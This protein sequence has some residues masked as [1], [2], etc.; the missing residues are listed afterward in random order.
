MNE[1]SISVVSYHGAKD[2]RLL[3]ESIER[4]AASSLAKCLYIV[5]NANE[6]E[7]FAELIAK[8][9]DVEYVNAGGNVGF[10][11]GHG[12]VLDRLDS[13]F[14]VIINPDVVFTEDSLSKLVEFMQDESIGMAVPKLVGEDGAMLYVYR[15]E[16][17]VFDMFARMF[18]KKLFPKRMR[19]V[20]MR[21]QDYSKPF[22]VPFAQGSFMCIRTD[23]WKKIGGFDPRY[24]MYV[25]DAD[26]C[27]T[28]NSVSK[29]MYAPCTQAVHKWEKG[30]HR[31][32]KLLK[33]HIQSMVKYM[34][35]WGW[36]FF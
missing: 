32:L 9:P 16:L 29:V 35:K 31:N 15:Q 36:K 10:G 11:K 19:W 28:V 2:V 23:L 24:F 5:D 34:N 13:K 25:E 8:Y 17:T 1:I 33:F 12:K 30:S 27:R 26:L 14:H 21:D 6:P 20:E 22:Q 3:V 4:H 18:C 7:A